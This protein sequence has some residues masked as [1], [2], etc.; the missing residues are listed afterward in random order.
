MVY[1][2]VSGK[3][4]KH[5]AESVLWQQ[6]DEKALPTV[7]LAVKRGKLYYLKNCRSAVVAWI[8][9]EEVY[10]LSGPLRKSS[11]NRVSL[12]ENGECHYE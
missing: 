8:K 11:L 9:H 1:K 2:V 6:K 12:F 5:N 4:L 3:R 10:K 7:G